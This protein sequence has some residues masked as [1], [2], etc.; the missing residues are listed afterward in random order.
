M[1]G[2]CQALL[3]VEMTLFS[4]QEGESEWDEVERE[5]GSTGKQAADS[6]QSRGV[7]H[8]LKQFLSPVFVEAFVLTFIAE[9]G[10]RSQVLALHCAVQY[11]YQQCLLNATEDSLFRSVGSTKTRKYQKIDCL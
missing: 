7:Q 10:D 8:Q 4:M 9:W 3:S 5:L 6:K 1:P 11:V 2:K